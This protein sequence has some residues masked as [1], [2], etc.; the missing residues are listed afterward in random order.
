[1]AR[2]RTMDWDAV[3]AAA[4][5]DK[6][7]SVVRDGAG[8]HYDPEALGQPHWTTPPPTTKAPGHRADLTGVSVGRLRVV[9]YSHSHPKG[10]SRWVV[11]CTCGDY[12]LRTSKAIEEPGPNGT[13]EP[14]CRK[15]GRME[16]MKREA[17]A[18]LAGVWDDGRP[19]DRIGLR[20]TTG[21]RRLK[22][23]VAA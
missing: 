2:I 16:Y 20:T 11:R 14:M 3:A 5:L 12:E 23:E 19:Y 10:G 22:D 9:G 13:H 21:H 6:A 15:C 1:M 8:E 7:A 4:P 18:A 17:K